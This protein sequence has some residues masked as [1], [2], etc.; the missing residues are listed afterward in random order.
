MRWR[1]EERDWTLLRRVL[2]KDYVYLDGSRMI[3]LLAGQYVHT[4]DHSMA[5]KSRPAPLRSTYADAGQ[6][7][8]LGQ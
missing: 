7:G 3:E 6:R 8:Q 5:A 2:A 4:A 1:P